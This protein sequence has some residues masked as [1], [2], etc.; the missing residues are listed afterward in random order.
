MSGIGLGMCLH[1]ERNIVSSLVF[2]HKAE[3]GNGSNSE[4]ISKYPQSESTVVESFSEENVPL[5]HFQ[6]SLDFYSLS[7]QDLFNYC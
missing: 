2:Q 6:F 4:I 7:F 3:P 1:V 5:C